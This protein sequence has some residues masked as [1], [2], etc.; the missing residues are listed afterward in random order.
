MK[1]KQKKILHACAVLSVCLLSA[2]V[3][4]GCSGC[5]GCSKEEKK[6]EEG[7]LGSLVGSGKTLTVTVYAYCPCARCNTEKWKGMVSTGQTMKQLL[8]EGRNICAADPNVIPMG[9]IVTY[10]GKEYVVA[11]TGSM[12]KGNTI[13]ILLD[14][15]RDVYDFGVKRDQT[16]TY[17]E[18]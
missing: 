3:M 17:R 10:D 9:S 8:D 2:V 1:R 4:T 15:H 5:S 12:I 18:N 6:S 13:N 16:I 11:D 7:I 14:S